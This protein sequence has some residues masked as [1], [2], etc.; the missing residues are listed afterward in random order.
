[1][2]SYDNVS[3]GNNIYN[4]KRIEKKEE[5]HKEKME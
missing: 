3:Q 1:M 5:I 4:I 2:H